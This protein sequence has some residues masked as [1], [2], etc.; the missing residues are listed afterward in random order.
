MANAYAAGA[1][2]LPFAVFRGYAGVDLASIN[3]AIRTIKCPFTGERLAAVPAIRPDVAIIHAQAADRQGNIL[4]EGIIGVQKEAVLAA[5]R[6][7]VTVE[8]VVDG[9][10]AHPNAC[11]LPYWTL[12]DI[13]VVHSGARPSYRSEERRVG[14][15]GGHTWKS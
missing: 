7:I 15:E 11:V 14:K 10:A 1:S 8:A 12:E 4:I 6:P 13:A 2:G 3:P 5:K 9:L